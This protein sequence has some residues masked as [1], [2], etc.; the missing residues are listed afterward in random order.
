MNIKKTTNT[1]AVAA[2]MAMSSWTPFRAARRAINTRNFRKVTHRRKM[3]RFDAVLINLRRCQPGW[4][5]N[6]RVE[7]AEKICRLT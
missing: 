6:D 4:S 7:F 2:T 5:E 1:A 3:K